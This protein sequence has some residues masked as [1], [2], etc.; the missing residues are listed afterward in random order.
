[1]L[2]HLPHQASTP[3]WLAAG[4]P[5]AGAGQVHRRSWDTHVPSTAHNHRKKCIRSCRCKQHYPPL[6]PAHISHSLLSLVTPLLLFLSLPTISQSLCCAAGSRERFCPNAQ[7]EL[8]HH[9]CA[10]NRN[11]R[12]CGQPRIV[13]KDPAALSLHSLTEARPRSKYC[14]DGGGPFWHSNFVDF[15]G[16]Y[17]SRRD[18]DSF[19]SPKS[20]DERNA[21]RLVVQGNS[22]WCPG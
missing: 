13:A 11:L 19:S 15:G 5:G 16:N 14:R 18:E 10:E 4:S 9:P 21:C 20:V 12:D 3:V 1:M 6:A 8:D 2:S 7:G 17:R 22:G